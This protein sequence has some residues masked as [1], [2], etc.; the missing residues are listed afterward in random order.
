[1]TTLH[2]KIKT[3]GGITTSA[4]GTGNSGTIG[5]KTERIQTADRFWHRSCQHVSFQIQLGNISEHSKFRRNGPSQFV[6]IKP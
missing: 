6:L 5:T 4:A 2:R 3:T 1:M